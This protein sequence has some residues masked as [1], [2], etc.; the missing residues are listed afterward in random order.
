VYTATDFLIHS[1]MMIYHQLT[2]MLSHG[3]LIL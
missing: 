2:A 1:G 3:F